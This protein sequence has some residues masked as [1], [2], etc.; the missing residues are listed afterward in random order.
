M[1]KTGALT[2]SETLYTSKDLLNKICPKTTKP[3]LFEENNSILHNSNECIPLR[4][5]ENLL[6]K[7]IFRILLYCVL[8]G[9]DVSIKSH[10]ILCTFP[11]SIFNIYIWLGVVVTLTLI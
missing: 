2:Y 4:S 3:K 6:T 8:T 5:L 1:L 10:L 9:T 11:V 7:S